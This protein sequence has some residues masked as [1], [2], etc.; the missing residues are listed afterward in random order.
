VDDTAPPVEGL[1]TRLGTGPG[2]TAQLSPNTPRGTAERRAGGWLTTVLRPA[3]TL[4]RPALNRLSQALDRLAASSDML[5][6]DL[7]ATWVAVPRALA[8]SLRAPARELQQ[9]GRCLLLIGAPPDLAAE[10]D[11]AAIQVATLAA[12]TLPRPSLTHCLPVGQS[13]WVPRLRRA[14]RAAST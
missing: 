8:R 11:R 3:G 13:G 10:L 12:E 5:I 7:T 9:P 6:V 14:L 1:A 4:D 2:G